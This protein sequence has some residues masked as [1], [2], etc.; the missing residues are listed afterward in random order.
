MPASGS[1]CSWNYTLHLFWRKKPVSNCQGRL[2]FKWSM[3]YMVWKIGIWMCNR[4]HRSRA[5]D[6]GKR[7]PAAGHVSWGC[8]C[9]RGEG[10]L[11]ERINNTSLL[12]DGCLV[13]NLVGQI[14]LS[15]PIGTLTSILRIFKV[16]KRMTWGFY[17]YIDL[18]QIYIQSRV[19]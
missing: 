17:L 10:M 12:K 2:N 14:I 5:D 15:C 4:W 13:R 11:S 6:K 8:V 18:T 19:L 3:H 1:V 7:H 9:I 16:Y